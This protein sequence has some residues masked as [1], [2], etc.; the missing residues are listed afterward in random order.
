MRRLLRMFLLLGALTW[1]AAIPGIFLGWN[2]AASALKGLG[3]EVIEYD[4]MLD[5]WLRM[6]SA[7]FGGIGVMYLLPVLQ[8]D[9]Y[10]EFVPW[11]GGLAL[12]QGL[13]LF[14]HGMRLELDPWP[15]VGDVSACLLTGAGILL[16]WWRIRGLGLAPKD[17]Q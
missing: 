5:Y 15:F 10:R 13:V 4:K 17:S 12:V 9:R 8:L 3:A 7:G 11:L 6:A 14:F 1:G 16:C 2:S